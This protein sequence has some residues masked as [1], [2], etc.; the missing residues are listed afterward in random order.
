MYDDFEKIRQVIRDSFIIFI[1]FALCILVYPHFNSYSFPELNIR[2]YWM[3]LIY[4]LVLLSFYFLE[5]VEFSSNHI[6][7]LAV[8]AARI[9]MPLANRIVESTKNSRE[10][11]RKHTFAESAKIGLNTTFQFVLI[12]YLLMLLVQELYLPAKEWINMN[13]FLITVII[14]G[15]ASV[16]IN[17]DEEKSTIIEPVELTK[18]DYIFIISA[19]II[20]AVIIWYKTQAIG[21]LS[22]LI[23]ILS[24]MLII[25]LS[26]LVMEDDEKTNKDISSKEV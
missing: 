8:I 22:Y 3:T 7:E 18:K 9:H 17:K 21:G 10:A 6:H 23:A 15:A 12:T 11:H 14:F 19:G 2:I 4:I 24:G 5:V 25:L 16:L 1:V 26:I 13:Y 20:G